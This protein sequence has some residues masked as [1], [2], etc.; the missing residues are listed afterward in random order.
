MNYNQFE[1]IFKILKAITPRSQEIENLFLK[2]NNGQQ[3]Q[4]IKWLENQYHNLDEKTII[5][6]LIEIKNEIDKL[7]KGDVEK[8]NKQKTN[9][10]KEKERRKNINS[11][12]KVR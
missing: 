9:V 5:Q 2:L 10:E 6:K 4:F 1:D 11:L 8:D 12:I 3:Q 7:K